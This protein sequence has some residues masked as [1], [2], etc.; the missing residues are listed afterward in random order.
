MGIK[1]QYKNRL[2]EALENPKY[3]KHFDKLYTKW[4]NED[5]RLTLADA[6]KIYDIYRRVLGSININL[7]AVQRFLYVFN[8]SNASRRNLSIND[9]QNFDVLEFK[10]VLIFLKFWKKIDINFTTDEEND[11]EQKLEIERKK[12]EEVFKN[13]GEEATLEKLDASEKLWKNK[14]TAV[15]DDNGLLVQEIMSQK[16]SIN[17]GYY[18]HNVLLQQYLF[19]FGNAP[20]CVT[21]R[22]NSANYVYIK[23]DGEK[24]VFQYGGKPMKQGVN[25]YYNYRNNAVFYFII[26]TKKSDKYYMSALQ[27][28]KNGGYKLTSMIN[29]GDKQMTYDEI[30]N[31]YPEL[32]KYK[33]TLKYRESDTDDTVKS[34]LDLINETPGNEYEFAGLKDDRLQDRYVQAGY[35]IRKPISWIHMDKEV[36]VK[37]ISTT[38]INNITIKFDNLYLINE[39]KKSGHLQQLDN[40][41]KALGKENGIIFVIDNIIKNTYKKKRINKKNKKQYLL[42]KNENSDIFGLFDYDKL[43]WVQ[44]DGVTYD[45]NYNLI[46]KQFVDIPSKVPHIVTIPSNVPHIVTIYGKNKTEDNESLYCLESP[47]ENVKNGSLFFSA[48]KWEEL[49]N[50]K[51]ITYKDKKYKFGKFDYESDSDIQENNLF[52]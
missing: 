37:Y 32:S 47:T 51:K 43:T 30:C 13:Q 2:T 21:Q 4:K 5:N 38:D 36:K 27:V 52:K 45:D 29:D 23:P 46:S 1:K 34:I 42:S 11:E 9:L 14:E 44:I 16:H 15:V 35:P 48:K 7:P 41:L 28:F 50:S 26:D 3:Q 18:Y 22:G 33:D 17:M 12:R 40:K 19:R 8:G 6:E 25:L 49:K 39:I 10:E 20:W 31:I 24:H